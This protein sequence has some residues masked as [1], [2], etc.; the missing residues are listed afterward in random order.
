LNG[1]IMS[2]MNIFRRIVQQRGEPEADIDPR[3]LLAHHG[4]DQ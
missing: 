4:L 1:E 3:R 2:P